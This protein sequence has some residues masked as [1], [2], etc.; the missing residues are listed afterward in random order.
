MEALENVVKKLSPD[1]AATEDANPRVETFKW[2]VELAFT[3]KQCSQKAI[4]EA[5]KAKSV[6][7]YLDHALQ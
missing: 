7:Q 4:A 5:P 1:P 3:M 6:Q 2:V